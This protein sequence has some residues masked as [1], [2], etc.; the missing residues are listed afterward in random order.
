MNPDEL[1]RIKNVYRDRIETGLITQYSLLR[2]GELFMAQ[3]RE[4]SLLELLRSGGVVD[5]A[6]LRLLEIGCGRALRLL[7]WVRW[8]SHAVDLVGIDLMEPLLKEARTNLPLAR[9]AVATAGNLPFRDSSFDAV[10]QL[11]VFSSILD[12]ELRRRV[13]REMWRVLRPG[14]FV[15]WYDLRYS[16]PH[17]PNVRPVGKREISM[18]FPGAVIRLRSN[19]LAPPIARRLAPVS[20]LVCDLVSLLPV[21]RTHYAA[22]IGKPGGAG[23][24]DRIVRQH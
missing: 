19:T 6:G 24:Q 9:F 20:V 12:I 22:L 23:L 18:L 16:N 21:L 7:D 5:V 13:A 14:G 2:P 17:N 15:L 11:T 10:T 4:R 8:G 1:A 3:Q